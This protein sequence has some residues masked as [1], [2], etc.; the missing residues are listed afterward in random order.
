MSS[1]KIT[2]QLRDQFGKG[3]A[4]QTRRAGLIPAVVYGSGS[5]VT[6]T[7][8]PE[9]ELMLALRHARVVLEVEVA[10]ETFVV[11]PRD[12]QRDPVRRTL[13]HLDLITIDRTE[14]A[15]RN[16]E[17]KAIEAAEA[18]ATEAGQ[19]PIAAAHMVDEAI[20]HGE[21]AADAASHAVADLEGAAVAMADAAEYAAEHAADDEPV[22]ATADPQ[23]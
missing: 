13:E 6:H 17:A 23:D 3:A 21:S 15:S 9:R 19:D 22:E 1:I 18:A 11:A 12:V 8:L 7:A 2:G 20:A 16:A 10:G 14:V 4:R 5:A